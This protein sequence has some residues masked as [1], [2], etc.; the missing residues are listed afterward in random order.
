MW[1]AVCSR[2]STAGRH[3]GA[4]MMRGG[5]IPTSRAHI[6]A[7]SASEQIVRHKQQSLTD[8]LQSG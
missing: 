2:T 4:K 6:P 8:V 5:A 3:P 7:P 1:S